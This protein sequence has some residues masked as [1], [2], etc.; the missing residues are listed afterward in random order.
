MRE[1]GKRKERDIDASIGDYGDDVEQNIDER[2][3]EATK[4]K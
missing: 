3:G 4:E 2:S 1:G